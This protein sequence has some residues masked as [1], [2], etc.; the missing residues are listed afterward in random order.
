MPDFDIDFCMDRRE[1]VIHYVQQKYGREK[2]AQI[3]TFGALLSK[4]AV[5]DV[6]RVLQMPYGQ[7][8]RLSKM[9]PVEGVKPVSIDQGAGRRAAAARGGQGEEVVGRLLKYAEQIEGLLSQR[10]DPRGRRGDRRPAAGRAGA[11]VPGPALG[12]AGHPVQ[13]EMGGTGRSGEVRLPGAEDADGDPE[14]DLADPRRRAAP[15]CRRRRARVVPAAAGG[16][17]RHRAYPAR[18]PGDLRALCRREDSRR[19]PGGKL[20]HDGCAAADEAHLHRGHRGAGGALPP[21]PDGEHPDLLRGQ[22]RDQAR[23]PR[24]TPR[25]TI[26]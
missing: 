12:H 3:I 11:S 20:G 26:S 15:A 14:R 10:L 21:R 17:E 13:H 24:S 18:R 23:S 9:I 1:E 4:A 8:D 5:R 22:E 25:S 7:V 2:V 16:G 19:V 6:G